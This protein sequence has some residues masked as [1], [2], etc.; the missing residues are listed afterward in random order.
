MAF[1]LKAGSA[2]RSISEGSVV[3][4]PHDP[5]VWCATTAKCWARRFGRKVRN[6]ARSSAFKE[7]FPRVPREGD[8]KARV[9]PKPM[10]GE[11]MRSK[12]RARRPG[13]AS[14]RDGF[15]NV[16]VSKETREGLNLLKNAMG[17]R[18]QAEVIRKLVAIGV[19][20]HQAND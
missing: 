9:D 5:S 14:S 4:T 17:V 11:D 15:I 13:S 19:A 6:I 16:I 12:Q 18:S 3:Q 2:S 1:L 7:I 20:I 10:K 8:H